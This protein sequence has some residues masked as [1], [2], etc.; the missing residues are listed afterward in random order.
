VGLIF[1]A[2]IVA[3][4]RSARRLYGTWLNQFREKLKRHALAGISAFCWAIWLSRNDVVFNKSP[5][6]TFL[7]VLFRGIHWLRSWSLME[8]HDQDKEALIAACH[9]ME[10]IAMEFYADH[11]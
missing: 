3:Q 4:P 1:L 2:F 5:I 9:K 6:K 7:H 10:A 11:G 8:R